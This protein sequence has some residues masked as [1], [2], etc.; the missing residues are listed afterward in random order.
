MLNDNLIKGNRKMVAIILELEREISKLKSIKSEV[1]NRINKYITETENDMKSSS[2]K[3]VSAELL[4]S[5]LKYIRDG[6]IFIPGN[7]EGK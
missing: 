2:I 3:W 6:L 7:K 4:I 5:D 1:S